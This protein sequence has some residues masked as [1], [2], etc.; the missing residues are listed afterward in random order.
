VSS[1]VLSFELMHALY[2][3]SLLRTEMEIDYIF[4]NWKI[5]DYSI[6]I[7]EQN[8]GVSVARAVKYGA[9]FEMEDARRIL[10]KKLR[11]VI[12]STNNACGKDKWKKQILHLWVQ[13]AYVV[14]ILYEC[15]ERF[16]TEELK[17]NTLVLVTVCNTRWIFQ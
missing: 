1:E 11:G 6:K 16:I 3:A 7:N 14:D 9:P 4:A 8:V 10:E 2:N 17:S 12:D 13:Q 15:Y 5:T